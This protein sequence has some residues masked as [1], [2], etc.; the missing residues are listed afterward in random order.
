M[1][2]SP[3]VVPAESKILAWIALRDKSVT[4]QL[5]QLETGGFEWETLISLARRHRMVPLLY[6]AIEK[7]WIGQP[8][9]SLL[10][11]I[12]DEVR[13]HW[14][15]AANRSYHQRRLLASFESE[16]ISVIVLKGTPLSYRLYGN[17]ALRQSIDIDLLI[18][19]AD[20]KKQSPFFTNRDIDRLTCTGLK[21]ANGIWNML[22]LK[23]NLYTL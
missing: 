5:E 14:L 8:P 21:L 17:F 18:H 2:K 11:N 13:I 19:P 10:S 20:K 3:I 7:N 15:Q 12:S 4:K 1:A 9:D 22:N 6:H 23:W 16:N